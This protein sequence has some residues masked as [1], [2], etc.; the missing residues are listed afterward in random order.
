VRSRVGCRVGLSDEMAKKNLVFSKG[1]NKG[2]GTERK[3]QGQR[4]CQW[5]AYARPSEIT[6]DLF[7]F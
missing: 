5:S 1:L 3:G 2:E 7:L 4:G 6:C